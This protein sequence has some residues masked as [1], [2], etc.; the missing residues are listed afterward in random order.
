VIFV[1]TCIEG[2]VV[3]TSQVHA[4]DRGFFARTFCAREF[5]DAAL[6]PVV[7]QANVDASVT[8]VAGWAVDG[9]GSSVR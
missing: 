5:E 9:V 8:R 4:D 1:P 7:A 6:S 2:V 3:V